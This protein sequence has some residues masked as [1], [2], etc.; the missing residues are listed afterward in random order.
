MARHEGRAGKQKAIIS[1]KRCFLFTLTGTPVDGFLSPDSFR[2]ANAFVLN[3]Y[4]ILVTQLQVT[5]NVQTALEG[6]L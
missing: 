2:H 4:L 6:Y 1:S 5:A 3:L